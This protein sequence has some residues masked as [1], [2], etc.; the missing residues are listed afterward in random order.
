MNEIVITLLV[1]HD[2]TDI[3]SWCLLFLFSGLPTTYDIATHTHYC[4]Y[5]RSPLA[6]TRVIFAAVVQSVFLVMYY[7]S[8]VV[9]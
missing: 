3:E 1:T 9:R 2:L 7:P 4:K 5:V 6:E 8:V